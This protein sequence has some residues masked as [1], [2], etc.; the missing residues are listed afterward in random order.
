MEFRRHLRQLQFK[1][2]YMELLSIIVVVKAQNFRV[3]IEC[4]F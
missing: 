4:S 2:T 3:K 1:I